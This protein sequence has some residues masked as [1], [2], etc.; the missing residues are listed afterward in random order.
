M[1]PP[2]RPCTSGPS[3]P[4]QPPGLSSTRSVR[5]PPF[6]RGAAR[7]GLPW[8]C[9][10]PPHSPGARVARPLPGRRA[11]RGRCGAGSPAPSPDAR[12][13]G[14]PGKGVRACGRLKARKPRPP[15]HA[16]GR[17][18]PLPAAC[19]WRA[20]NRS[21]APAREGPTASEGPARVGPQARAPLPVR[22]SGR[23]RR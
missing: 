8:P 5:E 18:L 13:R 20:G 23:P 17:G 1:S 19:G 2:S 6:P 12:S 11:L 14:D 4:P 9:E 21:C 15:G 3:W 7:G 22:G 16:A 10:R